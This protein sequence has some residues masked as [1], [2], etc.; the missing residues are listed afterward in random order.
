MVKGY[1]RLYGARPLARVIQEHVKKP[2]ANELLFGELV[3]GGIVRI[4]VKDDELTFA[5]SDDG[6]PDDA[7]KPK[8]PALV[9]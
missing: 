8:E 6:S 7:G 5:F 2:L 4:D 3:K 9:E 1:D